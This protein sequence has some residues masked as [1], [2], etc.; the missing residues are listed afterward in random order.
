M[1]IGFDWRDQNGEGCT[2]RRKCTPYGVE[3]STITI[4]QSRGLL[5]VG[6]ADKLGYQSESEDYF[7]Y[8]LSNWCGKKFDLG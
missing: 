3:R 4:T 6:G 7:R 2:I 8:P 5:R 1:A